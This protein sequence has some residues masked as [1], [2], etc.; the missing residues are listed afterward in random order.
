[1]TRKNYLKAVFNKFIMRAYADPDPPV[2]TGD[3]TTSPARGFMNPTAPQ[4][5]PDFNAAT[6]E[7]ATNG[8]TLFEDLIRIVYGKEVEFKALPEMRFFQH[9]TVKT[10]LGT[11]PGTTISM[12][13]YNN[14]KL[15]GALEEGRNMQTQA[16]SGSTKQLTVTEFGNA[17]SVSELMLQASFADIM[18]DATTLLGADYAL[19]LDME[20]RDAAMSGTNIVYARDGSDNDITARADIDKTC[21]LKVSTIKDAIEILATNLAR[22]INGYWIAMIHPHQSRNLRDDPAW[23]GVA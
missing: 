8:G 18:R 2:S 7:G 19:V 21:I 9:A 11:E 15:G 12:L 17:T 1:M 23:I 14:L 10:E 6:P 5:T 13:T 4:Y 20:L 16:M 22:K 3:R